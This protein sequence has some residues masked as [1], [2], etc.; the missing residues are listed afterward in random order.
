MVHPVLTSIH[1]LT[2]KKDPKRYRYPK[3][4]IIPFVN[5]L[6]S[7][8]ETLVMV[9]GQWMLTTHDRKKVYVLIPKPYV[10]WGGHF[11]RES[12]RSDNWCR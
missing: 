9:P 5:L 3:S 7:K 11:R 10:W 8:K 6:D 12:E 2:R 1:K 4:K